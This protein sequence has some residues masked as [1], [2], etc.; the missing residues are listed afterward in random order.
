MHQP[1]YKNLM[2]GEYRMPWTRLHALKDYYGMVKILDEFPGIHQTFNL[3]PSM[4]LQIEDY[5]SGRAADPFLRAALKPAEELTDS[6]QSFILQYFFHANPSR[7]IA[8]YPRYAELHARWKAAGRNPNARRLFRP[9]DLRDL[10]VLSQLAW[11]DEEDLER[12]PE[13][14]A[15]CSRGADFTLADQALI[16]K[17]EIAAM[18]RVLPAYREAAARGQI[19]ISTTPF[20]HPIL[21]LI[22]DTQIAEVSHPYVPLPSRFAYPSDAREQLERACEFIRARFGARPAGMWPSEGAVSDQALELAAQ[23]GFQWAAT[24]NGVLARTLNREA[25]PD[26]TYRPYVWRRNGHELRMIFRDHTL[27]DLIGFTYSR[28]EAEEA[29]AHFLAQIR[30]N[31]RPILESGRDALASIILDGENAWEYYDRNGRPFLRA[32]YRRIL[33]D[34]SISAVTVA[35]A[36]NRIEPVELDHIFP[37]SW[38]NANFDVWIGAEE[39]NR[40]WDCLLRARRAY[41]EVPER[42]VSEHNRRIAYEE[43][44]IAEGSDWCW[45]YGPEHES[46]ERP[47]FDQLYRDHLANVYRALDLN[48]PE[49][50]SRPILRTSVRESHDEPTGPIR[51]TIDGEVSSYFEW[52]GAGLYRVDSRSGAMHGQRFLIRE[53][54]YGSDGANLYIRLDFEEKALSSLQ[55]A[56]IRIHIAPSSDPDRVTSVIMPIWQDQHGV[57]AG[58]EY[59]IRKIFEARV[60]LSAIGAGLRQPV[61]FQLSLWQNG[62]PLDALP[63]QGWLDVSTAEPSDWGF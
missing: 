55:G 17:K 8:R 38:I 12:D 20:Y 26:V 44:L 34:G 33:E 52:M 58:I 25:G 39:D 2:T 45:W 24:D 18:A 11:F 29:A 60:P 48:P 7:L 3:A 16:E 22:C 6:E 21:P 57:Q 30:N 15:L 13:I 35:E 47:E 19:E 9:Q 50:L 56:Q 61:R 63:Q 37:G 27:S 28:M 32:L 46:A 53:L 23:T 41:D 36:L 54:Q 49:D 14:R 43:L 62:L 40:A 1:F 42:A 4:L 59:A 51:A 31:C 5:V 10:Q